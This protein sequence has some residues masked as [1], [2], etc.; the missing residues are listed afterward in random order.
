[1][2]LSEIFTY[3]RSLTKTTSS[4]FSDAT[5]LIFAKIWLHKIQREVASIRSDFF[6]T[7]DYTMGTL[8]QEDYP[9]PEDLLEL[10]SVEACFD[11]EAS[12]TSQIWAKATEIDVGQNPNAWDTIQKN[13][14]TDDPVFDIIDNRL[15]F[16]PIRTAVIGSKTVKIRLWYIERPVDPTAT[17][18]TP[19]ISTT[20][21]NLLDYQPL[22]A[23]GLCYDILTSLGSP[24]ATEFLSRYELGVMK[25]KK[26]IR[27]QNIGNVV[28]SI[29]YMDG[30]N[31]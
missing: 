15:Y 31:F 26:E 25:M 21:Q 19:L 30:S 27:Q 12:V 8:D 4:Q 6:G 3:S 1:M 16:A 18:D 23:E 20:N 2:E 13:S 24:R 22:L 7:K 11:A 5:L 9:L 17:T 28:A 29:P 10:K 14:T